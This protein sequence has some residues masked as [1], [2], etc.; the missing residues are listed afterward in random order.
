[1]FPETVTPLTVDD[2][3]MTPPLTELKIKL[4]L[5][6]DAVVIVEVA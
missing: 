3:N 1:M 4:F 5:P 2:A 6:P